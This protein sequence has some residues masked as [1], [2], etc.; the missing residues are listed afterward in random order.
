MHHHHCSSLSL[1]YLELEIKAWVQGPSCCHWDLNSGPHVC[2]AGALNLWTTSPASD[3][4]FIQKPL[5]HSNKKSLLWRCPNLYFNDAILSPHR[6]L[7]AL[8]YKPFIR[9]CEHPPILISLSEADLQLQLSHLSIT[10]MRHSVCT[11]LYWACLCTEIMSFSVASPNI[12]Q[13]HITFYSSYSRPWKCST[14]ILLFLLL[15]C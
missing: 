4:F 14:N 9:K 3:H 5:L 8:I 11:V 15:K 10:S 6:H 2:T 7:S 1:L 12:Y 13:S